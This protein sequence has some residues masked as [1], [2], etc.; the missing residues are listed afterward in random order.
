MM[1]RKKPL[2]SVIIPTYNRSDLITRAIDSVLIHTLQDFEIIVVDDASLD[3]TESVVKNI[4][5]NR[6]KYIKHSIN[7]HGS[8]ARNTGIKAATGQYIALLDSDDEWLPTHLET[9]VTYVQNNSC[10][11]VF[12]SYYIYYSDDLIREINCQPQPPNCPLAEYIL[13][14]K[15]DTRTSTFVFETNPI[16]KVLFDESLAKHQDWDLAIR[17]AQMYQFECESSS[18]VIAH[19]DREQSISSTMNHK[20]TKIFLER[21]Q[22]LISSNTLARFYTLVLALRT[23]VSEGRNEQYQE[24]LKIAK[25]LPQTRPYLKL[26][27]WC[28]SYPTLDLLFVRLHQLRQKW[29][30]WRSRLKDDSIFDILPIGELT[31]HSRI[32][33]T[34]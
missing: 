3:D 9:K 13:S 1:N 14:G 11:G 7:R 6:I 27:S 33:R 22:D 12:G 25:S 24:Y 19:Y 30:T 18:T 31:L 2:V 15:G 17:F 20:A 16:Q 4:T 23:L 21:Y 26:A 10:S 29:I 34:K 8:A 32:P 5:D 28:L